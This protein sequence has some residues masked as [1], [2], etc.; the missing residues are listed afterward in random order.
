MSDVVLQLALIERPGRL[1]NHEF[2]VLRGK[3]AC[4]KSRV[5]GGPAWRAARQV[6]Q[7]I[8]DA[9]SV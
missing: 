5:V 1:L 2:R 8:H 7:V 9:V 3:V 6:R 4:R